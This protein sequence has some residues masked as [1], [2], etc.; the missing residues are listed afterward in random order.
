MVQHGVAIL[1]RFQERRAVFVVERSD[2]LRSVGDKT[3]PYGI[4]EPAGLISEPTT[5]GPGLVPRLP[6]SCGQ[7]IRPQ[8]KYGRGVRV[9]GAQG[10][11]CESH[12]FAL[13]RAEE[14]IGR[15]TAKH[16]F[17]RRIPHERD[18]T[19]KANSTG[20]AVR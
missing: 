3:T 10:G 19:V 5:P 13:C 18:C 1:A 9:D 7:I 11:A 12:I 14:S 4:I 17:E 8:V 6:D 16:S 20:V 2:G 15:C